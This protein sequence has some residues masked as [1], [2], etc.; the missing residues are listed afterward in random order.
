[1][2][3]ETRDDDKETVASAADASTDKLAHLRSIGQELTKEKSVSDSD[4]ARYVSLLKQM[5]DIRPDQLEKVREGLKSVSYGDAVLTAV[6][7]GL[8]ADAANMAHL[9]DESE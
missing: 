8:L 2:T 5:S 6:V 3:A 7:D 9:Q 4:L 1:M